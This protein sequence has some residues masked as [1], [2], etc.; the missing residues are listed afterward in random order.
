M[1]FYLWL[2]NLP[3]CAALPDSCTGTGK[4]ANL[5]KKKLKKKKRGTHQTL[6]ITNTVYQMHI[7]RSDS[8][9]GNRILNMNCFQENSFWYSHTLSSTGAWACGREIE[10]VYNSFS[11]LLRKVT[12]LTC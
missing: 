8:T 12:V 1:L 11:S 6:L 2:I 3:D 9:T 10:K 4:T 7:L 5:E